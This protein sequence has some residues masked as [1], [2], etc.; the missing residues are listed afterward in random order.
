MSQCPPE[1]SYVEVGKA[2][3]FDSL[4][5]RGENL[6]KDSQEILEDLDFGIEAL[7]LKSLGFGSSGL[8]YLANG[9]GL[10]HSSN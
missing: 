6:G 3:D 9:F 10:P 8:G 1:F 2:V 4:E 5:M 7:D